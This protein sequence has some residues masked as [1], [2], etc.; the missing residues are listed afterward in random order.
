MRIEYIWEQKIL[1]SILLV[2][3]VPAP[4]TRK[5]PQHNDIVTCYA[6]EDTVQIV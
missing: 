3:A 4:E 5:T 2:Y 1:E 6:T